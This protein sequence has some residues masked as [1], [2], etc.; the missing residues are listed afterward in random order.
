[1]NIQFDSIELQNFGSVGNVQFS[2]SPGIFHVDGVNLDNNN[3]RSN[4]SGK[5]TIF[6]E[7]FRWIIYG[8]T[9]KKLSSD[10]IVNDK[11][12]YDCFGKLKANITDDSG[13]EFSVEI[14]RYRKHRKFGNRLEFFVDGR[15]ETKQKMTDTQAEI[16]RVFRLPIKVFSSVYL[17]EQGMDSK[18]TSLS[19]VDSK[20]YI[21][22][23]RNV[24]I[25]DSAW[26]RSSG[27]YKKISS[28][29]TDKENILNQNSAV[30]NSKNKEVH[31]ID[32]RLLKLK[33]DFNPD[34]L[35]ENFL[36]L[37]KTYEDELVV[38][39][40]A[41][42]YIDYVTKDLEGKKPVVEDKRVVVKTKDNE[43]S[44]FHIKI[45]ELERS[46][47]KLTCSACG[48]D[49]DNREEAESHAR[50]QIKE[51]KA[52]AD[53]I[54][55]ELDALRKDYNTHSNKLKE[56][57]DKLGEIIQKY[58]SRVLQADQNRDRLQVMSNESVQYKFKL[59][60]LEE[61]KSRLNESTKSVEESNL[62]LRKDLET[63][64]EVLPYYKELT[65]I[66]SFKGIRSYLIASD[67][68]FLNKHMR[69]F[70]TVLFSDMIVQLFPQTNKD[71]MV[72][73]LDT[74]ALFNTGVERLYGKLSGGERRRADICVQ[75]AIREF[76]RSVYNVNTNLFS[77]DEI[78]E[79]LDEDG[80]HNVMELVTDVSDVNTTIFMISHRS[81][82]QFSG[83]KIVV[84]KEEGITSIVQ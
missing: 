27:R 74:V 82:S 24:K 78:F 81:I 46:I 38:L 19:N 63:L 18:F 21:E 55:E 80:I 65:D 76:V 23:L 67:I 35:K 49:F 4:G 25:W 64:T 39:G 69:E 31:S 41:K 34:S 48:R 9:A 26:Y 83:G 60:A 28:E 54:S 10:G 66:F 72:T 62:V 1:M 22:S 71:G 6:S 8:S 14:C 7:S 79:G 50:K 53:T 61:T 3:S 70:S 52:Q 51:L 36:K 59:D 2:I 77:L 43:W 29:V 5:S 42:E 57:Y 13:E 40:K 75:L 84:Q 68:E 45:Q 15:N 56:D 20:N 58:S 47:G 73:T 37:K 44:S 12:D 32:E 17:M 30:I 11:R 33:E 16:E